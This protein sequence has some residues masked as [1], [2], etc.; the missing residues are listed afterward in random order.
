MKK[1]TEE[2]RFQHWLFDMDDVL[3]D[4]IE[5]FPGN[6]DYSPS[7]LNILENWLL[8]QY[9]SAEELKSKDQFPNLD[10]IGRYIGEVYRKNLKG[11]R[12]GIELDDESNVFYGLPIIK[13]DQD[14]PSISPYYQATASVSRRTGQFLY[15]V[16]KNMEDEVSK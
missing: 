15:T 1:E 9:S 5:K 11:V 8:K 14:L 6:L 13:F 10:A 2:E 3:E 7:S 16:F 4:F 12:W